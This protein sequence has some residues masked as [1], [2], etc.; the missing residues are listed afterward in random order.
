M[1]LRT[2]S[3]RLLAALAAGMLSASAFAATDSA[4]ANEWFPRQVELESPPIQRVI[5][6]EPV[7]VNQQMI[8]LPPGGWTG[9]AGLAAVS[10]TMGRK[11]LARYLR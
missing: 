3:T 6:P 4:G 7:V 5:Q 11:A 1:F 2:S 9:L 10:V 8:P